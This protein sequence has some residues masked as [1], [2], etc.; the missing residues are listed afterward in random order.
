LPRR[1]LF[2]AAFKRPGAGFHEV[3]PRVL[4]ERLPSVRTDRLGGIFA[5]SVMRDGRLSRVLG[6]ADQFSNVIVGDGIVRLG[7]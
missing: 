1:Q 2:L 4:R 6:F 3:L 7:H 5:P